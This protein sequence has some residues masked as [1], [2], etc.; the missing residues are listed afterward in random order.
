MRF[1][2]KVAI[3]TGGASGIGRATVL[4]LAGEGAKVAINDVNLEWAK[5]VADEVITAGGAAMVA[6][7]NVTV[8]SEV[9][10]MVEA[11]LKQFG[12]LDVLVANAGIT[13]D[14]F[15]VRKTKDGQIKMM[16]DEQWDAVLNVNLKGTWLC[17]QAAAVPMM[18]QNSGKMSLTASFGMLG[19]MGQANYAASKAGIVGLTRTLALEFAR[20]KINVNCVAPGATKTPMTAT[21]PEDLVKRLIDKVPLH[22]MAEPE[23]IANVHAFLVSEEASY[24]TGQCLLVDGGDTLGV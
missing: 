15:T 2:D 12:R 24:M 5:R 22:R 23:E 10:A 3:V 18:E 17:C 11:V 14:A 16:T 8:R 9:A 13:R 6:P 7:A 4:K 21:I 19:N 20:Y 1:N